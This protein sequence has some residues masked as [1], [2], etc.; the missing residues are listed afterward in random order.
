[1]DHELVLGTLALELNPG[2]RATGAEGDP[3][4]DRIAVTF[5]G[6]GLGAGARRRLAGL[7]GAAFLPGIGGAATGRETL[8]V[9]RAGLARAAGDCQEAAVL[10]E[11]RK[12]LEREPNPPEIMGVINV[13]PDSFSDGGEY[14]DPKRAVEHGLE[15][16]AQ[17]ATILDVGGESTRPGAE[18]VSEH[19][20]ARRVL[21][22]V[23]ELARRTRTPISID[24]RKASVARAALEAGARMVN[25]VS[26]GEADGDM[27]ATL[28]EHDCRV[29]LMHTRGEP[30]DMQADPRYADAPSE[31]LGYLRRRLAACAEAGVDP[32]R[33][34]VDPGIG[35]GKR[36]E[37]NVAILRRL[38]ELRSLG[39][40]I[41][42]GVSRKSFIGH[43]TGEGSRA[44]G[45]ARPSGP[46]GLSGQSGTD[47]VGGTS[48]AVAFSVLGGAEFLRV[49]D[50]AVML[51]S[52]TV[53]YALRPLPTPSTPGPGKGA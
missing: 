36:L 43:I 40:P 16:E 7:P 35:F 5:R 20:E 4:D 3:A 48:A 12:C 9:A 21:P 53:A 50:V 49:H 38:P 17:G 26:A 11:A 30:K 45:G 1:M 23:R 14:F 22:V 41:L 46:N 24:T 28:A 52:A 31:I 37:H 32:E 34:L 6:A 47:R 13:T 15:L 25:D 39:R 8:L 27:L 42:M 33:V 2:A 29:V 19:E 10:L 51:E 18:P 44:S